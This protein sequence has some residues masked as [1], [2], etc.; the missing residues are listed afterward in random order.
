M[1]RPPPISEANCERRGTESLPCDSYKDQSSA[2]KNKQQSPIKTIMYA[3]RSPEQLSLLYGL[4][5]VW[6]TCIVSQKPEPLSRTFPSLPHFN[7]DNHN[8]SVFDTITSAI[9]AKESSPNIK[10]Q[11]SS[12]RSVYNSF[13]LSS[14]ASKWNFQGVQPRRRRHRV[15]VVIFFFASLPIANKWFKYSNHDLSASPHQNINA[16]HRPGH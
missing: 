10:S 16:Y 3:G 4:A 1:D 11:T 12:D 7:V 8:H 6:P 14:P 5:P 2:S 9:I 15:A 13:P